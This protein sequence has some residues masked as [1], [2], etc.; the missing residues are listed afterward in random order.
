MG[1]TN[2]FWGGLMIKEKENLKSKN[3]KCFSE[4]SGHVFSP[5]CLF[6]CVRACVCVCVSVHPFRHIYIYIYIYIY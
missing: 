6:V 2:F 3:E 4:E 1:V 5:F